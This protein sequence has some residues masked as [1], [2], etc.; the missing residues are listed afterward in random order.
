[1]RILGFPQTTHHKSTHVYRTCLISV[2]TCRFLIDLYRSNAMA[3][4]VWLPDEWSTCIAHTQWYN[5]LVY[6][7]GD[8]SVTRLICLLHTTPCIYNSTTLALQR[9]MR[10]NY[11]NWRALGYPLATSF[12]TLTTF[13]QTWWTLAFSRLLLLSFRLNNFYIWLFRYRQSLSIT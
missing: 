2:V 4:N 9:V 6:K 12:I 10:E 13:K 3:T 7:D 1:M 11:V 5:Q 8:V